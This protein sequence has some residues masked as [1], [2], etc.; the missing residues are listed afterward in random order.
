[1]ILVL[2]LNKSENDTTEVLFL[3]HTKDLGVTSK[4][5]LLDG[6]LSQILKLSNKV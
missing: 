5:A 4:V 3:Q 1:M 6:D 2:H